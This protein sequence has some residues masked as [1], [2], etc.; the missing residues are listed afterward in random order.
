[1]K[2]KNSKTVPQDPTVVLKFC[3]GTMNSSGDTLIFYVISCV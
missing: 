2:S 3:G 1:M